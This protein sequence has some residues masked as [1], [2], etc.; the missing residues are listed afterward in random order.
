MN[1]QQFD[2]AKVILRYTDESLA[3]ALGYKNRNTVRRFRSGQSPIPKLVADKMIRQVIKHHQLHED[4]SSRKLLE[5]LRQH[6]G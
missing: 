6:K 2:K 1:G 5:E 4:F 3:T